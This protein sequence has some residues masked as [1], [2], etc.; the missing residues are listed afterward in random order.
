VSERDAF[1]DNVVCGV[2]VRSGRV[3]LV[4]RNELKRWAPNCWDLPGGHVEKG[5]TDVTAIIRELQEEIGIV[6]SASNVEFIA[7]LPGDSYDLRIFL[8]TRW[9]GNPRNCATDEHDDLNWFAAHELETMTLADS[10]I[11]PIITQA[12]RDNDAPPERH[13]D[14]VQRGTTEHPQ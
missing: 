4:H 10:E 2:L 6:V 5:E 14:G 11:I 13:G 1:F 3:L 12:I 9:L 8:V 7:R